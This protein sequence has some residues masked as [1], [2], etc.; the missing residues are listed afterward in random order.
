MKVKLAP[1]VT[2]LDVE[3][4]HV[5]HGQAEELGWGFEFKSGVGSVPVVTLEPGLEMRSAMG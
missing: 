2:S 1:I 5:V 4:Q 3:S